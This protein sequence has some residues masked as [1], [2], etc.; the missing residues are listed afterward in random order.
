[1]NS[2]LGG[3]GKSSPKPTDPPNAPLEPV[4]TV[5]DPP[6]IGASPAPAP[7]PAPIQTTSIAPVQPVSV[8]S[9]S[10]VITVGSSTVTA[11][12]ASHF[13]I[14][15]QT[16]AP[17]GPAITH[18]GTVLSLPPSGAG[19]AIGPSTQVV[20]PAVPTPAITVAGSTVTANSA[21]QFVVGSQTL[22]PGGPAITHS[23]TVVSL[24]PSA[25]AVVI[26]GK[27]Q[28]L[29]PPMAT[30]PP[31]ITI[32][33]QVITANAASQF[34]IGGQTLKPGAAP[35]IANGQTL[36]LARS[37]PVIVVNGQTQN[38]ARP[39]P[40]PLPVITV[41]GAEITGNSASEYIINGQ[42]LAAGKP[43]ITVSGQ[44][45]SIA[46]SGNAVV[47]GPSTQAF[48]T[49]PMVIST[50]L[51]V[52]TIG[53]LQITA[54]SASNYVIG[55]QTIH[56]GGSAITMDGTVVSLAPSATALVIGGSTEA[57]T[58]SSVLA[59]T[60]PPLI[61]LGSQI[62]HANA[63][64]DYVIGGQTLTPGHAIT[65]SGTVISL[66]PGASDVV[67]GGS[68]EVLTPQL[69]SLSTGL[70]VLTIGSTTITADAEGDYVV[71]GQTIRP[72]AHAITIGGQLVSL[73]AND[74]ML[75]IGTSTE[76]LHG[77]TSTGGAIT[78]SR[79]RN[80]EPANSTATAIT[81]GSSIPTLGGP[82]PAAATTKRSDSARSDSKLWLALSTV[83]LIT[84]IGLLM[85]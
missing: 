3:P 71:S 1:M 10:P 48:V 18:S 17:G 75:V 60:E 63:A 77:V 7:A 29:I 37:E 59:T 33:G 80:S 12:S 82:A 14:G 45:L 55:G 54:D 24:A 41:G 31:S 42:T 64:S 74:S 2:I 40:T 9:A 32:G 39:T 50:S 73:A 20:Q 53:A 57:L 27:T 68:T 26:A 25:S 67:I 21:S 85:T 79:T 49:P 22:T 16:L 36:S 6:P 76:M 66:A 4:Q 51:P 47:F 81:T 28:D 56:A 84:I 70:P 61:T 11:D 72:G 83:S 69:V 52:L 35:I 78:R 46:P 13:V 38:I 58:P 43:P 8:P 30:P 44:V 15:T 19:V 65:V 34:Q 23:G 5:A 62:L